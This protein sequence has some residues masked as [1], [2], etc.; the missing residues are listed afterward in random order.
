VW[1]ILWVAGVVLV[2][3]TAGLFWWQSQRRLAND[4]VDG[5]RQQAG[6]R[7]IARHREPRTPPQLHPVILKIFELM[8]YKGNRTTPEYALEIEAPLPVRQSIFDDSADG[9]T[10]IART[11]SGNEFPLKV[12]L[13]VTRSQNVPYSTTAVP[14][15]P[16]PTPTPFIRNNT[17]ATNRNPV[18][19]MGS[20]GMPTRTNIRQSKFL[21]VSLPKA[22]PGTVDYL[23]VVVSGPGGEA[24]WQVNGFP[25]LNRQVTASPSATAGGKPESVRTVKVEGSQIYATAWLQPKEREEYAWVQGGNV[26]MRLSATVPSQHLA[27]LTTH[28]PN[29]TQVTHKVRSDVVRSAIWMRSSL[30]ETPTQRQLRQLQKPVPKNGE[31]PPVYNFTFRQEPAIEMNKMTLEWGHSQASTTLSEG[32]SFSNLSGRQWT[33]GSRYQQDGAFG[34]EQKWVQI[35]GRYLEFENRTIPIILPDIPI[36]NTP[37]GPRLNIGRSKTLTTPEGYKITLIDPTVPPPPKKIRLVLPNGVTPRPR[38]RPTPY[39]ATQGVPF[40]AEIILPKDS[41]MSPQQ[42]VFRFNMELWLRE[43][44]GN[45][46]PLNRTTHNN[47]VGPDHEYIKGEFPAPKANR[48]RAVAWVVRRQVVKKAVPLKFTLPIQNQIPAELPASLRN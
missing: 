37:A 35:E 9:Y 39:P 28:F 34:G 48:Y 38:P 31:K 45:W 1:T 27:M 36:R 19:I 21:L 26:V 40:E 43:E 47:S 16:T 15:A 12:R 29:T 25:Q 20:S 33:T 23:E 32:G 7:L 14:V 6:L 4:Q 17:S 5:A 2:G 18:T 3:G 42:G 10:A 8:G 46:F 30:L 11:P 13:D 24:K 41:R 44:G 22:V